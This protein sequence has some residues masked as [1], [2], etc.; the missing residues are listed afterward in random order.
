LKLL[1]KFFA[2][3]KEGLK[4]MFFKILKGLYVN[5]KN[6]IDNQINIVINVNEELPED[7]LI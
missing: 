7:N 5:D 1:N 4:F 2:N 3:K 6:K